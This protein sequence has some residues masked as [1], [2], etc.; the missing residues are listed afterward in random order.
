MKVTLSDKSKK[1][2][3]LAEMP[4]VRKMIEQLATEDTSSAAEYVSMVAALPFGR[5]SAVKKVYDAK[6]S[7]SK[8][9]RV[10]DYY[11][12]NSGNLDVWIDFTA[13]T[14]DGFVVGGAYLSDI[15]SLGAE[16]REEV[17]SNMYVKK[18]LPA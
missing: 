11:A 7:I 6:A 8:N 18:F 1:L 12:E 10:N 2:V 13:Q 17:L 9:C 4:I 14:T 5:Y 15:W 16:T 3:T